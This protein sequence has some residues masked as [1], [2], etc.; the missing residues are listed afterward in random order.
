MAHNTRCHYHYG[1]MSCSTFPKGEPSGFRDGAPIM[2]D[3]VAKMAL[4]YLKIKGIADIERYYGA[5]S[6]I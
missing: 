6:T 1:R 4:A 5:A 3:K 2:P